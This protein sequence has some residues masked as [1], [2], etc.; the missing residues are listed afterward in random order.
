M[1]ATCANVE[2]TKVSGRCCLFD[3]S[4][5]CDNVMTHAK[6]QLERFL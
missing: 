5:M 3:S 6:R 2:L 4:E 1:G